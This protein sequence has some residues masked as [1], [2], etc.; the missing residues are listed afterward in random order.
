LIFVTLGA[1]LDTKAFLLS[2]LPADLEKARDMIAAVIT[3]HHGEYVFR[4]GSQ[5]ASSKLFSGEPVDDSADGWTGISRTE[6]EMDKLQQLVTT[7]VEEVGGKVGSLFVRSLGKTLI[8]SRP[9]SSS[10]QD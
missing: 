9:P 2:G 10:N 7:T 5:P 4:I 6:Q 3:Q 8:R 1:D